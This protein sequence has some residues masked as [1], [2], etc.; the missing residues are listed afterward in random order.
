MNVASADQG[1][2]S[3]P[4]A[5]AARPSMS[6]NLRQQYRTRIGEKGVASLPIWHLIALC[7]LSHAMSFP[8]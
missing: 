6:L 8:I 5:R 2:G 1:H 4:L 3:V 7:G